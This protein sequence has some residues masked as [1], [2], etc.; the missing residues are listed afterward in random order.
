[1][2]YFGI[3][4]VALLILAGIALLRLEHEMHYCHRCGRRL[5]DGQ[6]KCPDCDP[7]VR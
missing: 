3:I 4:G 6:E 2:S 5:E 7:Y 1:M